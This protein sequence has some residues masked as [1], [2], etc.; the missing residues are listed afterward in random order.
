MACACSNGASSPP[1]EAHRRSAAIKRYLR[2]KSRTALSMSREA[3]M[4]RPTI[5]RRGLLV[6]AGAALLLPAAAR[7]A[8]EALVLTPGQTHEMRVAEELLG[9]IHNAYVIADSAYSAKALVDALVARGCNVVIPANPTHPQ[10]D[11][12]T[13]LYKDRHLMENFFQRIKRFR[14]IAMRFEK[15]ARNFLAFLLLASILVWLL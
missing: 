14:R 2:A 9:D 6:G 3:I 11:Y 7:S 5:A 10:R 13:H 8:N 12:D 1:A 4:S 15:L